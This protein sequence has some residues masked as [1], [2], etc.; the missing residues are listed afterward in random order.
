MKAWLCLIFLWETG[1]FQVLLSLL[2][3]SCSVSSGSAERSWAIAM[4][5]VFL[6][7]LARIRDL[8]RTGR[9]S[10]QSSCIFLPEGCSAPREDTGSE[11]N[12]Q[13]CFALLQPTSLLDADESEAVPDKP[14]LTKWTSGVHVRWEC[15]GPLNYFLWNSIRR[16][17]MAFIFNIDTL[18]CAG[19]SELN[20]VEEMSTVT[21]A[22]Q[23]PAANESLSGIK[24]LL[25]PSPRM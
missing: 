21:A 19:T 22:C 8:C 17:V 2:F 9:T 25:L 4:T 3:Q 6:T 16:N 23:V 12:H 24:Q 11:A 18:D 13:H 15:D 7:F 1:V 10:L 5:V 20:A 14:V